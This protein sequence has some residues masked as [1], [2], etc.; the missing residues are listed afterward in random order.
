[1]AGA[2]VLLYNKTKQGGGRG[3]S[4]FVCGPTY[5]VSC[6]FFEI[7]E[8]RGKST[9]RQHSKG[10][11]VRLVLRT[12]TKHL[13][14]VVRALRAALVAARVAFAVVLEA[15]AIVRVACAF[16]SAMQEALPADSRNRFHRCSDAHH[17][18]A[19]PAFER[20]RQSKD[21]RGHAC[22][23]GEGAAAVKGFQGAGFACQAILGLNSSLPCFYELHHDESCIRRVCLRAIDVVHSDL[24]NSADGELAASVLFL[25]AFFHFGPLLCH[26]RDCSVAQSLPVG[27]LT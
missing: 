12:S 7:N 9:P 26:L 20:S 13:R 18:N 4:F 11:A 27:G 19:L 16:A 17:R 6:S 5:E 25:R 8:G 14:V 23:R 1:M 3:G 10:T 15:L 2:V 22:D 21:L 24:Y